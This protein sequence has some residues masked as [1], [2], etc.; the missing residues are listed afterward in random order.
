L[1]TTN[2]LRINSNVNSIVDIRQKIKQ[3]FCFPFH[4]A[5]GAGAVQA[6]MAVFGAEQVREQKTTQQY[7][8]R[9]Y[10]AV[11][12]GGLFAFAFIAY[13]QQN[14]SYFIGYMVPAG[15]LII[16]L[17][18]FLSGYK[19][20][21]HTQPDASIVSNFIPVVI[22]AFQT[23]RKYRQAAR[24]SDTNRA[25]S[26]PPRLSNRTNGQSASFLDYAKISNEGN[27]HDRT[28]DDIKSL[29]RIIV[30]FLLLIPYWLIYMQV[31]KK[32][33][34]YL[35]KSIISFILN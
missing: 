19:F 29:R 11:N 27:F 6:N 9:Y 28:V 12:T 22:N 10:A 17:I 2:S 24:I 13:V 35:N 33:F 34:N 20:Y 32:N 31:K 25:S 23:R 1:S 8:D 4:S 30:V 3:S 15:L 16:A 5:I 7:F 21:I 26:D 18:L 14:I